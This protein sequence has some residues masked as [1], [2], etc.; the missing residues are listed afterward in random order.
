MGSGWLV[1]YYTLELFRWV[2]IARVLLSW[3][4]RPDHPVFAFLRSVTD[5][6]LDPVRAL[7]PRTPLD[8]SPIIVLL[9]LSV[10]QGVV[11]NVG[12]Y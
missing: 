3:V 9:V 11:A 1:L 6:V 2:L 12:G 4:M 8:F 10:L 5:P 7:L